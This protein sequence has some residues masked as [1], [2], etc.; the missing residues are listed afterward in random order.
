[1]SISETNTL[2]PSTALLT[3]LGSICAHMEEWNERKGL[4]IDLQSAINLLADDEVIKWLEGMDKLA[5]LPVK[6]NA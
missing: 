6:R 4:E 3:K 5:L 2:K 1:M